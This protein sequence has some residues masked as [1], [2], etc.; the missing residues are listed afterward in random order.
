MHHCGRVEGLLWRQGT[1]WVCSCR[2]CLV[3]TLFPMGPL[4]TSLPDSQFTESMGYRCC[5]G[6]GSLG[7]LIQQPHTVQPPRA[8]DSTLRLGPAHPPLALGKVLLNLEADRWVDV[9]VQGRVPVNPRTKEGSWL[10]GD[11]G[12]RS[13]ARQDSVH[14][15]PC[16]IGKMSQEKVVP[17]GK[18]P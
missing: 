10:P 12:T 18:D 4:E 16:S 6:E 2:G 9:P 7:K 17:A 14:A 13:A 11:P 15:G 8:Q 3:P 1:V 5:L